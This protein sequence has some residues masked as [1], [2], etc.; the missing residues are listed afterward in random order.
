[1]KKSVF[2]LTK[3]RK[4]V[5]GLF[6][7]ALLLGAGLAFT[8]GGS[9]EAHAAMSYECW[10][11]PNGKPDKMAH[12]VADNKAEA[13]RLAIEKFRSLDVKPIAVTCK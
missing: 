13:V 5:S 2:A 1:M 6:A 3:H 12:V 9:N 10:T 11:H 4:P 8:P 7:A